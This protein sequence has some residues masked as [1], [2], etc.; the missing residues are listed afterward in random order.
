[1]RS[2]CLVHMNTNINF[3]CELMEMFL[4]STGSVHF[5]CFHQPFGSGSKLLQ[6]LQA[7]DRSV[8]FCCNS[9][10]FL[11]VFLS[12]NLY[13][14]S[15]TFLLF[16]SY[17]ESV[18]HTFTSFLFTCNWVCVSFSH[19][20]RTRLWPELHWGHQWMGLPWLWD[21]HMQQV[22]DHHMEM[23]QQTL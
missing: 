19:S 15:L 10:L 8:H 9:N 7:A 3:Y 6:S 13:L 22:I 18:L 20:K 17:L 4:L 14:S 5:C 12:H 23:L 1:M 2:S 21:G 11:F 16:T